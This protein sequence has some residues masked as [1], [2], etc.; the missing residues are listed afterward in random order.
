VEDLFNKATA[1]ADSLN[2]AMTAMMN[3]AKEIEGV[4][5][6]SIEEV[7]GLC[8]ALNTINRLVNTLSDK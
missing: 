7:G 8:S 3:C 4:P 5:P 1:Q 2:E 6:T